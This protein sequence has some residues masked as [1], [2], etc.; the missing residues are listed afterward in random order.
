[1]PWLLELVALQRKSAMS[2]RLT[3][4]VLAGL[5]VS[6]AAQ[7]AP[8]ETVSPE[9]LSDSLAERLEE[10][11]P[12]IGKSL[13]KIRRD[14]DRAG[15]DK[16]DSVDAVADAMEEAF[17]EG[18]A[19]RELGAVLVGIIEDVDVASEDGETVLRFDG[20]PVLR[21]EKQ[22]SRD[23]EDVLNLSGLGRAMKMKRETVTVDGK[24]KSKITIELDEE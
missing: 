16:N 23:S 15:Q 9:T 3:L 17:S 13:A 7:A 12:E 8:P 10:R 14:L 11:A 4:A 19:L 18:G 5:A 6:T 24:T 2:L 22:S 1:M 21:M 20:A